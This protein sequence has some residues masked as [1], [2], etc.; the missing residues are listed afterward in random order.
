[1]MARA[2]L[3]LVLLISCAH[4][5]VHVYEI[6][7]PSVEQEIASEYFGNDLASG[8][9]FTGRLSNA[10]RLMWGLGAVVAGFFVD[11]FGSRR[12]LAVYLLGC[13][14]SCALA[15]ISSSESFLFVAMIVMGLLAS[16]YHP[17]GLSLISHETTAENRPQALGIHGIFGST[18]ISTAPLFAGILLSASFTWRQVYWALM[19]PGVVLGAVFVV[20]AIRYPAVESLRE[21][22]KSE[23][24]DQDHV[25]WTSFL[26]LTCMA[27]VQGFI[28]SALM[29]FLPR[30]LSGSLDGVAEQ[31]RD[32]L[33]GSFAEALDLS[34]GN[35]LAAAVLLVGCVGQYLAGRFAKAAIL[36]KQLAVIMFGNVPFLLWMGFALTW[37]RPIAAGLLALVHFMHQPIYNS[38]IAKYTPRHRRSLCYGFSFAM[39]LGLGS[40]GALFAG[41]FQSDQMVY[42]SLAGAAGI[43]GAICCV[44]VALNSQT[45]RLRK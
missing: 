41:Y 25:D 13:S 28:Y 37:H 22:T 26:T 17:A 16:I 42:G 10:W 21:S 23:I 4:A 14:V 18:G 19:L 9:A 29:S 24:D 31:L 33:P 8:K 11:R 32:V 30:Y 6:S 20:Q 15:A 38:L 34:T 1:M 2:T 39:G 27:S 44:L 12:L 40:F 36:E 5:L 35:F 7:L 45:D 3:A 43:G